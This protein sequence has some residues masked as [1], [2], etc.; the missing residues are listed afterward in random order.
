M[1]LWALELGVTAW[2]PETGVL[3]IRL[4]CTAG[5]FK[6]GRPCVHFGVGFGADFLSHVGGMWKEHGQFYKCRGF[7][8][9]L[10]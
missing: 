10:R 3:R 8:V 4:G 7:V 9:P 1:N 5:G 6:G 2:P